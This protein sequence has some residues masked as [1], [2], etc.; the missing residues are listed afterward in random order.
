MSKNN[1]IFRSWY[2]FRSGWSMYFAFIL[3]AINT[4]T[5][6]YFLAIDNYPALKILFPSFE[7]YILIIVAIGIPV[8]VIIGYAHFKRTQA[9]KAE[10]DVWIE[11]NPYHRRMVVNTEIIL[12]LNLKLIDKMIKISNNEAITEKEKNEII[13]IQKEISE[14]IKNRTFENNVELDFFKKNMKNKH[15]E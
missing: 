4:L 12:E 10:T 15:L 5:V 11:S 9:Y 13:I 7:I 8:L 2:Y 14:L 6:T 3:A 1:L